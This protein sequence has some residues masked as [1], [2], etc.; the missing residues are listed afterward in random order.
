MFRVQRSGLPWR[1]LICFLDKIGLNSTPEVL[2]QRVGKP[3]LGQ[4][5]GKKLKVNNGNPRKKCG[6]YHIIA[7]ALLVR[8]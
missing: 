7:N 5:L 6:F 4:G 3:G 1:D 8:P 2:V